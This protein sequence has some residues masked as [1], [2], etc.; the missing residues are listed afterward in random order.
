MKAH[1]IGLPPDPTQSE[2]FFPKDMEVWHLRH[3]KNLCAFVSA[4]RESHKGCCV[5]CEIFL[6]KK[7]SKSRRILYLIDSYALFHSVSVSNQLLPWLNSMI[8]CLL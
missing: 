8:K 6:R 5:V 1:S 2:N 4:W 7:K 3:Q